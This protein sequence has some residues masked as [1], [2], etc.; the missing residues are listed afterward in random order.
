MSFLDAFNA[1]KKWT[2][3]E[4]ALLAATKE[5]FPVGS[6]HLHT[7]SNNY[8]GAYE[9]VF[10]VLEEAHL[11]T[12]QQLGRYAES[13]GWPTTHVQVVYLNLFEGKRGS[14]SATSDMD[15]LSTRIA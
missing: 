1:Y 14:F 13:I 8:H 5:R 7:S 10:I 3:D 4:E 9:V 2:R 11:R 6:V 12:F 15:K